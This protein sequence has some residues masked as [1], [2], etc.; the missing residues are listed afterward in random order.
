MAKN[1]LSELMKDE[2][3]MDSMVWLSGVIDSKCR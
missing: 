1:L 2:A 3:S